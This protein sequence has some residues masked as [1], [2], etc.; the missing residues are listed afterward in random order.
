MSACASVGSS[1]PLPPISLRG[2]DVLVDYVDRQLRTGCGDD[3]HVLV[4][5]GDGLRGR[6]VS[7]CPFRKGRSTSVD[8]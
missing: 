3:V 4:L 8:E 5:D 2:R 7:S 6:F 1:P